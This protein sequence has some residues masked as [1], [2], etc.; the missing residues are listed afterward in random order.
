MDWVA[1]LRRFAPPFVSG[2]APSGICTSGKSIAS[3]SSVA[4]VTPGS[5]Q[6]TPAR[7]SGAPS[8]AARPDQAPTIPLIL[9]RGKPRRPEIDYAQQ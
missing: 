2:A 1:G 3:G 9:A 7:A 6:V 8:A 4:L 5:H